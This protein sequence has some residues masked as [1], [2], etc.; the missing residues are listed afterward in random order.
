MAKE[1]VL[2]FENFFTYD[3][4]G[5]ADIMP[6]VVTKQVEDTIKKVGTCGQLMFNDT[7]PIMHRIIAFDT[8]S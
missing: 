4:M 3:K 6:I 5:M 2:T 8:G 1:P 7:I